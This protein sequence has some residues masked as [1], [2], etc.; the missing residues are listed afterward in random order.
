MIISKLADRLEIWSRCRP[1]ITRVLKSIEQRIVTLADKLDISET[2]L[3]RIDG[4]ERGMDRPPGADQ[5]ELRTQNEKK[6]K[7]IQQELV[8]RTAEAISAPAKRSGATSP[9]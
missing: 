7:T 9:P 5:A 8:S 4:V 3:G 1:P 6:L 2:L